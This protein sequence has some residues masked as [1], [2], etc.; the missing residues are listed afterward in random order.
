LDDGRVWHVDRIGKRPALK[1][2]KL[3]RLRAQ[4]PGARR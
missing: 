2:E 1:S 4:A 3:K